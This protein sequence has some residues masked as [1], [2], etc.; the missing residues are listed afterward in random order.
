MGIFMSN[1]AENRLEEA[2]EYIKKSLDPE[3]HRLLKPA[4]QVSPREGL[5]TGYQELDEKLIW[6]GLPQ[7]QLSLFLSEPGFG[8]TSLWME[9][10]LRLNRQNKWVAWVEGETL[11]APHSF[12]QRGFDLSRLVS[13]SRSASGATAR[14]TSRQNLQSEREAVTHVLSELFSSQLFSMIGCDLG[15]F[16]LADFQ[17][18]QL[19]ALARQQHTA[20][21]FMSQVKKLRS[22]E[23]F[24]LILK[25]QSESLFIERALHRPTP[26]TLSRRIDYARF[27]KTTFHL[28][29]SP[30]PDSQ[31]PRLTRF[32]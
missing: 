11:L 7:G 32:K 17:L 24:P 3:L 1:L 19:A 8:A 29:P 4:E 27:T 10:A 26:Q 14:S 2:R 13:V 28:A 22:T 15:P 30:L 12:W 21:V 20:L 31:L 5:P 9:T 16:M 25:F 18:R 6:K 23:L